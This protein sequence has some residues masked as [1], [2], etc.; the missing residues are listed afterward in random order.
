MNKIIRRVD[1][2]NTTKLLQSTFVMMYYRVVADTERCEFKTKSV[3]VHDK[4]RYAETEKHTLHHIA[5]QD[6]TSH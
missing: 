2:A 6:I 3:M 4:H 1:K 5:F